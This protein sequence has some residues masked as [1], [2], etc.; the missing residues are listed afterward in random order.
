[1][2][3]RRKV[4][5]V[6]MLD[7]IHVARWLSQ[8]V[9]DGVDFYIFPSSPHRR[10]HPKIKILLDETYEAT[11]KTPKFL[12]LLGA[13]AWLIEKLTTI[14]IRSLL[15]R[16]IVQRWKPEFVHALELQNAGYLVL[17]SLLRKPNI[18]PV[19]RVIV[20]NYGSDIF[21]FSR[22]PQHRH[23]LKELLSVADSYSCE[24][25]RD[26][27]LARNLGFD[28]NVMPVFP[29]AG[30][31]SKRY[32]A[33]QQ[34]A[35]QDRSSI[36]IKGYQGWVG[37]AIVALDAVELIAEQLR[38][39][40]IELYSCNRSTIRRAKRLRQQT[41]LQVSWSAKGSLTHDQMMNLFGRSKVYVGI[42]ESDGVSTSLLEAM[43]CGAIP[44]QTSTACCD[45]WFTDT[46]V[47]VDS[48]SPEAVADAILAALE[49]AKD[50]S[51]AERNRQTIREKASEEEVKAAALQYYR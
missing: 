41:G 47:R 50:P 28:G 38:D 22:F 4:L 21:W 19:P 17:R 27:E 16:K 2:S 44:V 40:Q 18:T 30:G 34:L 1:L 48:I 49:L 20:T 42:S 11:F 9:D 6:G 31:F 36:A 32:L 35:T 33:D 45:E 39:Y 8:F 13:P 3:L 37:R 7:S 14:S 43:A 15:L 46:G 25:N 51:N 23:K 5:V 10:I 12:R 24:C 29:N 26:V